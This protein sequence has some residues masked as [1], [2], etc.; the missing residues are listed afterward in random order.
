MTRRLLTG[1]CLL[2]TGVLL[3]AAGCTARTPARP[4]PPPTGSVAAPTASAAP[5]DPGVFSLS[6]A[7]AREVA[8]VVEF[9][10]AC[11]AGQ[12][13]AALAMFAGN[14]GVSDC[15]YQAVEDVE[16]H[17]PAEVGRWLRQRIAEHDV[18]TVARIFNENPDQPVGGVGVEYQRRSSDTL[19]ALGFPN[20]ITPT[21][22]TKVVFSADDRIER[23]ANGPFGGPAE[24]CRPR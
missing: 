14:P 8:V 3:F 7:Q 11:N 23:F 2:L 18:L 12:L 22:A 4:S 13:E 15:D 1:T 5:H 21:L 6:A 17:G 19:R 9:L 10:R 24:A 16:F 20:G